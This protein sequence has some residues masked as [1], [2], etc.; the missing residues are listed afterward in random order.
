[1][2]KRRWF[3]TLDTADLSSGFTRYQ[4]IIPTANTVLRGF[5]TWFFVWN[6]PTFTNIY[7]TIYSLQ[8]T[9]PKKLLYAS[10]NVITK[11][12]LHTLDYADKAFGMLFDDVALKGGE[13]YALVPRGTGYTATSTAYLGWQLGYPDP[14]YT[15]NVPTSSVANLGR[16]PFKITGI[17]GDE[18]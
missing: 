2:A 17:V 9:T 5:Q 7:F 18:L 3:V 15:T 8:G 14:A 12:E 1:M 13:S 16:S 4:K 11:A 10:T 6:N